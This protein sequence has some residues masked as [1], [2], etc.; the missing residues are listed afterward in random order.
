MYNRTIEDCIEDA[1]KYNSSS[2][3]QKNSPTIYG[4]ANSKKWLKECS[5]HFI[6]LRCTN[7]TKEDC[8][9]DAKKYKRHSEWKKNSVGIYMYAYRKKWLK[10]CTEHFKIKNEI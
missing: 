10:E 5:S 6:D 8:I 9:A 3:W 7:R 4:Y 2:E 1:K